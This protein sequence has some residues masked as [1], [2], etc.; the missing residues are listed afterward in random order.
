MLKELILD[1]S[2]LSIPTQNQK[3]YISKTSNITWLIQIKLEILEKK[4]E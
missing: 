4:E 1:N 3:K 2:V